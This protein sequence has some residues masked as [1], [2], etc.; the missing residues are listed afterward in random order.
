MDIRKVVQEIIQ[1]VM[2]SNLNNLNKSKYYFIWQEIYKSLDKIKSI[3]SSL[4]SN[5]SENI[6]NLRVISIGENVGRLIVE[7][8]YPD[9]TVVLFYKSMSGTSGKKQGIWYPLAGF[10][11]EKK[12]RYPKDWFIKDNEIKQ[13]YGSK[14]FAG[15]SDYLSANEDKLNE[16]EQFPFVTFT[17]PNTGIPREF[18]E[19]K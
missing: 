7:V 14:T 4:D 6:S 17:A 15:T 16:I 12:G 1:K 3:G 18:P 10:L 11:S 13:M 8:E 19:E 2:E 9:G 5:F